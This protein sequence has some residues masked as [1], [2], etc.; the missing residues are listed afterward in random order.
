MAIVRLQKEIGE[1]QA[2]RTALLKA[3]PRPAPSV[4]F[5][6]SFALGICITL[7]FL[8]AVLNALS[9]QSDSSGAITGFLIGVALLVVGGIPLFFLRPGTKH[10]DETI[11][12]Q[13]KSLDE[14]VSAKNVEVKHHK[15]VVAL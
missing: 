5:A 6:V 15:E 4:I 9:V 8:F 13:L 3:S 1:L 14:Q 7:P 11:G 2:D 10:W 12:V